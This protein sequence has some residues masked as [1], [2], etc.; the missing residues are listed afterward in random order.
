MAINIPGMKLFSAQDAKSRVFIVLL[1]AAALGILI[2]FGTRYLGNKNAGVGPS[3]VAGAP[4]GLQSIPGSKTSAEYSRALLQANEQAA[5]EAQMSGGSAVPTLVNLQGQ[6]PP[7]SFTQGNCSVVCPTDENA[8][9]ANDL[10]DLVKQGSISAETGNK[11]LDLAK[12]NV[13]VE[14]YA[15]ALQELVKQGKLTPEQARLLLDRYKKQSEHASLLQSANAMDPLIK[16]GQLPLDVANDLLLLQ[17]NKATPE[18]YAA[19]L[20]RLVKEGKITPEMA[21]QL[22]AQYNHQRAQDALKQNAFALKQLARQGTIT[23]DVAN[24]LMALQ[25][26]NVPV[27]EYAAELQRLVAAGKLTPAAAAELLRQ[28]K[29]QHANAGNAAAISSVVAQADADYVAQIDKLKD[30]GKISADTA[31]IL[32][33]L[34]A[35]NLSP[36][37]YQKALEELVKAG[38]ITP[39]QARLLLAAYQKSQATKA[40]AAKL[41]SLQDRNVPAGV[42]A[43][44]LKQAVS[45]GTISASQ[46]AAL[47]QAYQASL[48]PGGPETTLGA[49]TVIPGASDFAKLQRQ[50]QETSQGQTIAV[51]QKQDFAAAAAQAEREAMQARQQRIQQLSQAMA[52]QAQSLVSLS[53]QSPKMQHQGGSGG[54]ASSGGGAGGAGPSGG[55]GILGGGKGAASAAESNKLVLIKMGTVAFAVLDTAVDSDF[56]DTPVMATIVEGPLKG[57]KLLGKLSLVKDQDRISL[58]FNLMNRDDWEHSKSVSAFAIDPDTARTV[59]ASS[60]NHHYLTRYGAM[61]AASFLTGYSSAITQAGT[62]TT[63]IFGTSTTHPNLSPGNRIAVGLGQIGTQLTNV[64]QTYVNTPTTVKINSGVGLGILFMGDVT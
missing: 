34:Q 36:A 19:E 22:L 2:F 31:Q 64:V 53:W 60:V 24:D 49:Q 20:Q 58:S 8:D 1:V 63:G 10:N 62:S 18:E 5:Q 35:K 32:K 15:A 17:K 54:E 33:D 3:K 57:A 38:K 59:M 46:A 40:E 12:R 29:E 41:A 48:V 47:M 27:S 26:K 42:F 39:E 14:E 21:A 52:G 43:N 9:V 28:Y 7:S 37:D 6:Q 45:Q 61:M 55:S 56:P 13:S 25:S 23:Q 50:L 4:G 51:E 16:S 11:L 44:E 30:S